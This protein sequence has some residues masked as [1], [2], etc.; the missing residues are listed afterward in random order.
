MLTK[1]IYSL[2]IGISLLFLPTPANAED[3]IINLDATTPY[4]DVI[5]QV[6]TTTAYTITTTT[7][8]RFEVVDSQ[9][10]ERVA[11]VDS[12]LWLY[13]GVADSTTANPIRGDDDSNHTQNNWL[14]SAISGTLNADTYTIRATSYDYVVAGQRPIGTYT[15][16]SNL[17]P[18]LV[19]TSTVTTDTSTVVA[20]TN[21][22]TVDGTTATVDTSTPVAPP[23]APEPPAPA[24]EPPA[25]IFIPPVVE[26]EP[27][28]V[29]EEPPAVEEPPIEI[30]EP[31]IEAEEPP[32]VE[33]EAP[34]PVEEPPVEE[35]LPIEEEE[36]P[37]EE[38]LEVAQAD[39]VDLETLAPET[40]V[41]LENGVVLEAGTVVALQLLENPAELIA[42]I[43]DNP[44]EVFTALSNIG[45]DMSEE[46]REE[47][48]KVIIASVIATQAA[49]GAATMTATSST[50]TPTPTP[51]SPAGGPMAG[52][53]KPRAS[54]RRAS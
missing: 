26:P 1:F 53:D 43:F 28:V 29:V 48:E 9:T 32:D 42:A 31:P 15:L 36:L 41:Q 44:A 10:V 20:D 54:R 13:R 5:V 46:E 21:T 49:V 6:D 52:N 25:I 30:E 8:P 50:R 7:G 3:I 24:P 23:P 27:P 45:A 51:S 17:I 39:E 16:S 38:E 33:E 34:V 35:E 12:W 22:A 2:A 37:A 11:W 14:A 18:P 47:S 40:P 4:V 19:D